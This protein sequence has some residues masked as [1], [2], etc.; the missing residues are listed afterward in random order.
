[1][2]GGACV[3]ST[4][5]DDKVKACSSKFLVIQTEATRGL[6]YFLSLCIIITSFQVID[7][8]NL[9]LVKAFSLPSYLVISTHIS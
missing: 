5:K 9:A 2:I 1:M 7:V 8:I 6:S 4:R 3:L